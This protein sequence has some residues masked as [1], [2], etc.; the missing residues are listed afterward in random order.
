MWHT[1]CV[2]ALDGQEP[3]LAVV[4]DQGAL[5]QAF[6]HFLARAAFDVFREPGD[7][8]FGVLM[9]MN[10]DGVLGGGELGGHGAL[11]IKLWF[12]GVLVFRWRRYARPQKLLPVRF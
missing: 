11:L 8:A 4:S 10:Q 1:Q 9:C 2:V 12:S 5:E 7:L 6:D 3:V